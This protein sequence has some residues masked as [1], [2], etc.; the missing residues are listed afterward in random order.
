M[1]GGKSRRLKLI[2]D[3]EPL[4]ELAQPKLDDMFSITY[5][6][7]STGNPKGVVLTFRNIVFGALAIVNLPDRPEQI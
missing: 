1:D 3:N 5:T 2:N 6:S 7:G 4:L